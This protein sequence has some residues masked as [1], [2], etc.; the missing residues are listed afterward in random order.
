GVADDHLKI[1]SADI[2]WTNVGSSTMSAA[3]EI[4]TADFTAVFDGG[5]FQNRPQG[6]G[7][8]VDILQA[9][10]MNQVQ[11]RRFTGYN[12]VVMNFVVDVLAGSAEKAA[13]RWYELR[14]TADGDPWTI[15]QEGTYEA[16]DGRD[17]YSA[18]MAMNANG[19]IGMAYTSSSA[20]DRISIRYTGQTTGAT[21]SVM[22]VAE[23]LIA[24]STGACPS[25]GRL[26]D[27]V[28]LSVDPVDQSFWHIAEYYEPTRR[29][30][31]A[32]FDFSTAAGVDDLSIENSEL[33]I[34]SLPNNQFNVMLQTAYDGDAILSVFDLQG[35][36]LTTQN[37]VKNG[38]RFDHNLDMAYATTG[39]YLVKI[40]GESA[41]SSKTA[42]IIVK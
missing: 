8:D 13:V 2:D 16:P 24:Q 41:N 18:S 33:V 14:Q 1:W 17:A 22:N 5:S 36:Q 38:D 42:K 40:Q 7:V 26:A 32:H 15:F 37:L 34:S 39:V 30:V 35:K 9:T 19:E 31:V 28:Q 23:E 25:P 20:T 10:M 27:Y 21:N 4:T 3:Q 6:G 11:Y 12:S 29:D